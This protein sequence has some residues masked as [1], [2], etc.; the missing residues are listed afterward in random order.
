MEREFDRVASASSLDEIAPLVAEFAREAREGQS[1]AAERR[2]VLRA[3]VLSPGL[4]RG[5]ATGAALAHLREQ[6]GE[7]WWE[8]FGAAVD[9]EL[10][11]LLVQMV[12]ERLD[13]GH[14][15]LLLLVPEDQP[16]VLVGVLK[17]LGAY[18]SGL[19]GSTR[20]LRG[21]RVAMICGH[22][23]ARLQDPRIWRR[24]SLP[25]CRIDGEEIAGLKE[26]KAIADLPE[27]YEK[28]V[29]Q[30]QRADL[31][32]SLEAVR[33]ADE[34]QPLPEEHYGTLFRVR[35][36]LRLGISSA[37]A[38]D[39]HI[40]SK[41]QGG[42]TLNLGVDL[43]TGDLDEPAPPLEVT[44]RRLPEPR[45]VLRSR[46]ADFEADFE[47]DSRGDAAAQS[48]LFFAFRRG[49]DEALRMTKQALVHTGIVGAQSEDVAGDLGR[50]L[51]GGGLEITTSSAV[52]QGSGLGTSS[53][54]A[55]AI[56]K[57]LYRITGQPAGGDEG[58][59][60]ALYDQSVLLEQSIGLNSGW[61]D[62]RG[63]RGGPSA[64]KD[65][66]APP[67][68]GLP[69]PELTYVDVDSE[70]FQRRV[71]LFDTGIARAATRGLNVVMEAYLARDRH[72]YGAIRESMEIHDRM[73]QALRGGD[74]GELGRLATRY[75][76]LRCLLDPEATNAA[77]QLLFE[78]PIADL[79]EGGTL[80][81]AGGGGFSLLIARDG[82]ED[83]LRECLRR[84][85]DQRPYARSAVVDYRLDANGL[86]LTEET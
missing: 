53:I 23:Y 73:V 62:A 38:S 33:S 37:N 34:P 44:A 67:T 84:L 58:E 20:R 3:L 72:R 19:E 83:A 15:D 6:L 71:V 61:Q 21:M 47:L 36:P 27:A 59:Y 78:S 52:Q 18:V 60:P 25:A 82:E 46:S 7:A 49:G 17:K 57:V 56:L 5:L 2:S 13:V 86:R 30:L 9:K 85:K 65:F 48:G 55:A 79:T 81:G 29:G 40:R 31:R 11:G 8:T 39:N 68:E 1:T 50:L 42:K 12:D 70:I 10:P 51:G 14:E 63:V 45:L 43:R 22:C 26:K 24:R 74:Y 76:E 54:L 77:I 41:E 80:T 4:A 64:V 69:A 32:R 28:R 16:V 75:W 35:S 66:Y